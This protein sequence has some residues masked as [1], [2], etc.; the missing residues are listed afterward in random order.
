MNTKG[1]VVHAL[2]K[3]AS[4]F[5]YR[6]FKDLSQEKQIQ[7]FSSN[8]NSPNQQEPNQD[9]DVSFCWCPVRHF[10][11]DMVTDFKSW[12][13]KVIDPFDF[14]WKPIIFGKYYL[15]YSSEFTPKKESMNHRRKMYPGDYKEKLKPKTI[16]KLNEIFSDV[17]DVFGYDK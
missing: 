17:L 7:Y 6:I 13:L 14:F 5:L 12:L 10:R 3:T 16:Y 9:I 8:K 11:I 15:K 4:M 1:I 2:H